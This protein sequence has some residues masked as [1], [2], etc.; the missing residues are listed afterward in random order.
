MVVWIMT[1]SVATQEQPLLDKSEE[2]SDDRANSD[3]GGGVV[4]LPFSDLDN[5]SLRDTMEDLEDTTQIQ[6]QPI[7]ENN[8]YEGIKKVYSKRVLPCSLC[9][10]RNHTIHL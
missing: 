9:E 1:L 2:S 4:D 7:I 6:D 5:E 3:D 10:R 8:S